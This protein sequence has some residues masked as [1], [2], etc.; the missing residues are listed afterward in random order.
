MISYRKR[1]PADPLLV[2]A[3]WPV[4]CKRQD[5]TPNELLV[6]ITIHVLQMQGNTMPSASEVAGSMGFVEPTVIA[7]LKVCSTLGYVEKHGSLYNVT[8]KGEYV[9]RGLQTIIS[10]MMNQGRLT[11]WKK[12]DTKEFLRKSTK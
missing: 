1:T 4:A 7:Y 11:R 3:C 10:R 8:M 12:P 9:I 6:L 5:L 2:L